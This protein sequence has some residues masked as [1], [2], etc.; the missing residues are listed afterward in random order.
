MDTGMT[1][2]QVAEPMR[3]EGVLIHA[4]GKTQIRL[5]THLD[6]S[7]EDIERTLKVFEKA[8]GKR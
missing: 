7:S 2:A 4:F 8:L 5:V 6:V 1:G 3:R